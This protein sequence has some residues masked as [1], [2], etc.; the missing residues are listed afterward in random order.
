VCCEK[1]Q[2][3]TQTLIMAVLCRSCAASTISS[4]KPCARA[5]I[6]SKKWNS[7]TKNGGK[8]TFHHSANFK[9]KKLEP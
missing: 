1:T 3:S 4:R 5:C 2:Y 6:V 8:S 7:A 9:T